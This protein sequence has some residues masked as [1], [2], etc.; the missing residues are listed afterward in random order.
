MTYNVLS[1]TLSLYTTLHSN[2]SN[3]RLVNDIACSLRNTFYP[4]SNYQRKQ[5]YRLLTADCT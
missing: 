4:L 5:A 3:V 2:H 1:G